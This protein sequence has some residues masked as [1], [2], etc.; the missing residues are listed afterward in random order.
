MIEILAAWRINKVIAMTQ[1]GEPRDIE[2]TEKKDD[3]YLY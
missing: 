3:P 1:Q 2:E